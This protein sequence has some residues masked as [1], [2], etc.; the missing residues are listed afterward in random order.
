MIKV[1]KS[2]LIKNY[3]LP[4]TTIDRWNCVPILTVCALIMEFFVAKNKK[5][6]LRPKNLELWLTLKLNHQNHCNPSKTS[7][8]KCYRQKNMRRLSGELRK[9]ESYKMRRCYGFC[10]VIYF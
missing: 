2:K 7:C 8:I 4:D 6:S 10:D 9:V 5:K 3:S 1:Q